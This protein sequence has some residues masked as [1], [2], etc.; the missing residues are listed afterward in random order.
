M[1]YKPMDIG[2][3]WEG[4]HPK[5]RKAPARVFRITLL[6]DQIAY[7]IE[8]QLSVITRSRRT[9]NAEQDNTLS[10]IEP[11]RPL[12]NRW[13]DKY[14]S[15]AKG[16]MEAFLLERFSKSNVNGI[17]TDNIIEIKLAMP[18]SWDE[19]VLTQLTQSIHEYV[20]SGV[21]YEYLNL[22]LTSNDSVTVS[23]REQAELAY[24]DIKK[25]VCAYKPGTIRKA[26]HP[27]P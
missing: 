18:E 15:S 22:T 2:Q 3:P 25:Y 8:A 1:A 21:T 13:I 17:G 5:K 14:V 9:G 20:S 4:C 23:K 26:M 6:R 12:F 16:R 7:D 24:N 19:T 11:Y 10:D 27:F